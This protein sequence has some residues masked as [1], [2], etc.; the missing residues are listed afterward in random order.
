MDLRS[1][2]KL[3]PALFRGPLLALLDRLEGVEQL[4]ARQTQAILGLNEQVQQL[5]AELAEQRKP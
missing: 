3:A 5:R 2:I 1:L 4:A